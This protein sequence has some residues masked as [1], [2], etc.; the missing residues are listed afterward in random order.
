MAYREELET[1]RAHLRR[2]EERLEELRAEEARIRAMPGPDVH[3]GAR[4][5]GG[6]KTFERELRVDHAVDAKSLE[7]WA[8]EVFEIDGRVTR[9]G[10][11]IVWRGEPAPRPRRVEVRL[12]PDARGTRVKLRDQGSYKPYAVLLGLLGI[13]PSLRHADAAALWTALV[14]LLAF[15]ALA[16]A[17][18]RK[19]LRATRRRMHQAER[20]LARLADDD[21]PEARVRVDA[22]V[23]EVEEV[24]SA[25]TEPSRAA[26]RA[27]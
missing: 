12:E 19:I 11:V 10:E 24:S 6:P 27:R 1:R 14:A 16:L 8:N 5:L 25:R 9:E 7:R 20:L 22:P 26:R 23:E 13:V 18:R 15:S 3:L 17:Q 4:V 2:L 21:V